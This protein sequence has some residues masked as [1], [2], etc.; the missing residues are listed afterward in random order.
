MVLYII[1]IKVLLFNNLCE[2]RS[3]TLNKFQFNVYFKSA[4]KINYGNGNEL[5]GEKVLPL[6]KKQLFNFL[7]KWSWLR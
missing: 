3:R 2:F 6:I 1:F 7:I 5:L 4:V